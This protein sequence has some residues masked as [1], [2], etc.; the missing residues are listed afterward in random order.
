MSKSAAGPRSAWRQTAQAVAHRLVHRVL[1]L[2]LRLQ[3]RTARRGYARLLAAYRLHY[4]QQRLRFPDGVSYR[5]AGIDAVAPGV[6]AYR[7]QSPAGVRHHA[8]QTL[9]LSWQN[10]AREVEDFLRVR[11][12]DPRMPVRALSAGSAYAPGRWHRLELGQALQ[13]LIDVRD[14]SGELPA[15]HGSAEAALPALPRLHARSYSITAIEDTPQGEVIEILVTLVEDLATGASRPGRCSGYLSRRGPQDVVRGWP[16]DFPMTLGADPRAMA[17][18]L[19]V[20]TGIAAAGPLFE[21]ESLRSK[22]PLWLVLGLRAAAVDQPYQRRLLDFAQRHPGS[23]I[24]VALSREDAPAL[25]VAPSGTEM[26]SNI[27]WHGRCHV[28]DVLRAQGRRWAGLIAGGGDT[29]VV[30]HTSMGGAVQEV[31]R[32]QMSVHGLVPDAEGAVHL[33]RALEDALRLQYSLSG[34]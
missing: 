25:G 5:L 12:W 10:E 28:Q 16:L 8:G 3:R 30:G 15:R 13:T 7:L 22:R 9:L 4:L 33:Q 24:D 21:Y 34:R 31:L 11:G 23:R 29:V 27:H 20:A 19:I 14:A 6:N 26:P 2:R 1:P 17:P 18:L 32:Q